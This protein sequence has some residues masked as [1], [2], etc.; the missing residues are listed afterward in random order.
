MEDLIDMMKSNDNIGKIQYTVVEV[1]KSFTT[2]EEY[3]NLIKLLNSTNPNNH[4]INMVFGYPSND[5]SEIRRFIKSGKMISLDLLKDSLSYL[6]YNNAHLKDHRWL[7]LDTLNKPSSNVNIRL[8]KRRMEILTDKN[9]YLNTLNIFGSKIVDVNIKEGIFITQLEVW[10]DFRI[11]LSISNI[12]TGPE[13]SI[14]IKHDDESDVLGYLDTK[15]V[16]ELI[17]LYDIRY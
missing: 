9:E 15:N 17:K 14:E 12:H 4:D 3:L 10:N 1:C 5:G 6:E 7:K 8:F 11:V 2:R 13:Y 16:E